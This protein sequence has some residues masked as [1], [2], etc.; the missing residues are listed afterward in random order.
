MKQFGV[1][2]Q[3]YSVRGD[4]EKDFEGT[5]KKV[6]DM[7]I[8]TVQL[9]GVCGYDAACRTGHRRRNGCGTLCAV[10]W[11][12]YRSYAGRKPY[13]C[14]CLCQYHCH[15]HAAEGRIHCEDQR[16]HAY[17]NPV[18]TGR[19][20]VRIHLHLAGLG[21]LNQV[22]NQKRSNPFQRIRSF[23]YYMRFDYSS[24]NRTPRQRGPQWEETVHPA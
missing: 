17:R 19:G 14:R 7:G 20:S 11:T 16:L 10:F 3:L 6:A 4:M 13:S 5:L 12:S 15:R 2:V 21:N 23:H 1:G 18:L 22:K 24:I 9:S 8:S